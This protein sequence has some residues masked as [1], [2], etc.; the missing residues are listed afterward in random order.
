MKTPLD[1]VVRILESTSALQIRNLDNPESGYC[2]GYGSIFD[3][4]NGESL[5]IWWLDDLDGETPVARCSTS[6]FLDN[7]VKTMEDEDGD[8]VFALVDT[9]GDHFSIIPLVALGVQ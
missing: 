2:Y 9:H 6:F 8:M 5:Y 4:I 3:D 1:K 7:P